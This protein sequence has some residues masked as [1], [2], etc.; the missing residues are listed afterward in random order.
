MKTKLFSILT[1]AVLTFFMSSCTNDDILQTNNEKQKENT[2]TPAGMTA[3]VASKPESR[4]SMDPANGNFYWEAGDKIWVQDDNNAWQQSSNAPD[5]KTASFTF[6]L[7]GQ[8]TD[9]NSYTVYYTGKNGDYNQ[10]EISADQKQYEPNTTEHRSE[11]RRV[12]KECRSRW[13][14][15]H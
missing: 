8:F 12:G 14:P 2:E 7:P 15:Y 11:E 1:S 10:V 6:H 4:T 5:T 3:F 9:K 13:S